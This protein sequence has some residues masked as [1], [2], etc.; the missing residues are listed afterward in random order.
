MLIGFFL[1]FIGTL[2]GVIGRLPWDWGC[3]PEGQ[4][5]SKNERFHDSIT[6]HFED[7]MGKLGHAWDCRRLV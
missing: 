7:E 5:H 3:L 2:I 1:S 6:P 4:E